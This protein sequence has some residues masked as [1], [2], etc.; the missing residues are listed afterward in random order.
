[1]KTGLVALLTILALSQVTEAFWAF[2]VVS[3]V[4]NMKKA[5]NYFGDLMEGQLEN[6]KYVSAKSYKLGGATVYDL[7]PKWGVVSD[8]IPIHLMVSGPEYDKQVE[9]SSKHE[10]EW[11]QWEDQLDSRYRD[12]WY[13]KRV[14][15]VDLPKIIQQH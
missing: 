14:V 12:A 13:T 15:L 1:M 2:S 9:I 10:N 5:Y 6:T 7:D 4:L 3:G 8:N 11:K